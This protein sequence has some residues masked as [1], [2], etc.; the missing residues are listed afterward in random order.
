MIMRDRIC[1]QER[2]NSITISLVYLL[3]FSVQFIMNIFL[4]SLH[5]QELFLI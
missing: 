1:F 3:A 4:Y 5:L 2:V